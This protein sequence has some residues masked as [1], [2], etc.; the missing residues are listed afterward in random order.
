MIQDYTTGD[1]LTA[2]ETIMGKQLN[3]NDSLLQPNGTN[4]LENQYRLL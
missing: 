2:N 1:E 3:T 4:Y